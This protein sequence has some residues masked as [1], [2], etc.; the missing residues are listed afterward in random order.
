[1]KQAAHINGIILA[2][3]KSSR[4][5]T[6]KGLLELHGKPFISHAI[7]ALRP[8]VNNL[9]I[10]SDDPVYDRFQ[11]T[12]VNDIFKE[13]GPLGGLYSG[14]TASNTSYNLVLSCDVPL[15]KSAVLNMLVSA[16]HQD[17]EVIQLQCDGR[18]HPLIAVYQKDCSSCLKDLLTTG[19][20]RMSEALEKL[21]V[22]TIILDP[23]W[24]PLVQNIN[25]QTQYHTLKNELEH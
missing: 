18:T 1:M 25:T 14:L 22:K 11:C 12:R 6:P 23:E 20:R 4:M 8:L 19:V 3:G 10:V 9:Y 21:R 24:A 16:I 2:G 17:F 15:I 7:E 13:A 5:G